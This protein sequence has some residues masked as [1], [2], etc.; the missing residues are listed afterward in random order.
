MKEKDLIRCELLVLAY[1]RGRRDEAAREL[2]DL[3]QRPALYY[4]RRLVRS[5][6]DAWD[7]L[8][9]TF[10]SILKSIPTLRDARALPAFVYRTARNAA[11]TQNRRR[12][13]DEPLTQAV[14]ETVAAGEEQDFSHEDAERLHRA[15]ETLPLAQREVLTLFF[16]KDLSLE[17]IAEVTGAAVGTV[18]SR[19]FYAK[20][21]LRERLGEVR[22]ER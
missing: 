1:K 18:K 11:L 3:F 21:A 9:E 5:E 2:L 12:H 7:A 22:H 17:Q 8:Q 15:M 10:M 16:L 4:I 14:Q 20:R 19:M 13:E 6:A